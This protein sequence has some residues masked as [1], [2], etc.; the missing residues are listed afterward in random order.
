MGGCSMST[1]KKCIVYTIAFLFS[2]VV[3]YFF[4]VPLEFT[5]MLQNQMILHLLIF[6]TILVFPMLMARSFITRGIKSLFISLPFF[7][8]GLFLLY[9]GFYLEGQ[10]SILD[11]LV[12]TIE[13]T[14]V[15]NDAERYSGSFIGIESFLLYIIVSE[16]GVLLSFLLYKKKQ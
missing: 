8:A 3:H 5:E 6:L 2:V 12:K 13:S 1:T 9:R 7:V 15:S 11:T 4:V 10:F 16:F 14:H